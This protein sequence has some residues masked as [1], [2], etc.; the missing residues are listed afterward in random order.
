M[1]SSAAKEWS[2]T[3]KELE[4]KRSKLRRLIRHHL[5]EH[6]GR[7]GNEFF[8]SLVVY[9]ETRRKVCGIE[10]KLPGIQEKV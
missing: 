6:H 10:E 1:P 3:F 8:Y 2:G 5:Q 7:L 4:R 9:K